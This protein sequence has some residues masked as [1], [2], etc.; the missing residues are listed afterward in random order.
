MCECAMVSP[1]FDARNL[2][3]HQ[4][5]AVFE[6]LEAIVGPY[7]ESFVVSRKS[8]EN[9]SMAARK[10]LAKRRACIFA[11]QYQQQTMPDWPSK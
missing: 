7:L 11:I 9:A 5:G 8:L 6:I 1:S 2:R 3:S 4:S 10:P